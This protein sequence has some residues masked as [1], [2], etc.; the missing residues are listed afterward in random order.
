MTQGEAT[1]GELTAEEALDDSDTDEQVTQTR[2]ST[3]YKNPN[4]VTERRI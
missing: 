4:L 1:V 2:A 3:E